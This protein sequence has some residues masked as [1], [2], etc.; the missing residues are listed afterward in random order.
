[1]S[2]PT[3]AAAADKAAAP[4]PVLHAETWRCAEI[5]FES[6][7]TYADPFSDVTLDLKLTGNGLTY[8]I[9]CFWDGGNVWKARV[10]CPSAGTWHYQTLCSDRENTGL[11]GKTG[12]IA[13][14][15]YHGDLEVYRRGFV[16]TRTA[17][18]YFTY[19][20]GTPF[21]YLGDTH[22]SLGDETADMVREIA[23]K[24]AA[25]GYSVWQSEPIGAGFDLTDGV[26]QAD[27]AGFRAFD[28]KFRIIADAGLVHANAQ[29]FYPSRMTSLIEKHGGYGEETVT[30]IVS[31]SKN[32]VRV[33][34]ESA[35]AYLEQISRYWVARYGAY[36]VMWTLGQEVDKAFYYDQD[37]TRAWNQ[38]NHPYRFVARCMKKYDAYQH[39]LTAHQEHSDLT[40]AYGNECGAVEQLHVYHSAEPSAFRDE[41]AHSFYA[42]QWFPS[43]TGVCDFGVVKDY[44]FNS[45]GKPAILYEGQYCFLWTKN[46][47]A[48]MQGWLAYLN[49]MYGCAWGGQDTWSYLNS[50]GENEDSFDG[51]DTITAAEKTN[52]TWRDA[53]AYP[54]SYQ[55]GFMRAFLEEGNWWELLPRFDDRAYFVPAEGV[56]HVYASNQSNT[57]I[58]L[59]F[60]SFSD[61][62][63]A[64]RVNTTSSGGTAT[65]TVGS[66]VPFAAYTYQWF[67][68]IRGTCGKSG[69]FRAS[70]DGTFQLGEKPSA[71]DWAIRILRDP[72]ALQN[73]DR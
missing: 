59:Y 73:P 10:A 48:R 63:V 36:P 32:T 20:D 44:W 6:E 58:V 30:G 39:P 52:A 69:A 5:C 25:Q 9:P 22:W 38:L 14:A 24:R 56:Y 45:Q 29:F 66:L 26:T 71:T 15:A 1:M 34:S 50:Y 70:S 31:G 7:K 35:K 27:I 41:P 23:A 18:K 37:V 49:G 53:L 43:K 13:C 65:G 42:A 62:A 64:E 67:D 57:E 8:T 55:V 46:F 12:D 68:P 51:A 54:S 61:P 21:F 33:L 47:G 16:T 3:S 17:K 28:E 19:A 4:K 72:P 60:Y 11:H 40:S 2:V